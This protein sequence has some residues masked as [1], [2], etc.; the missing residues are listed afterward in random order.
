MT[1]MRGLADDLPLHQWLKEAVWPVEA[2]WVGAEMVRDGTRLAIAEMLLSGTTCFSDQYY[3]PE[4]VA[5]AAADMHMRA[6]VGTPVTEYATAWAATPAECLAKGAEL[7][8]DPFAEHPLIS[9]CF[10][11][12]SAL[13]VSDGTFADL[14]VLADQLDKPIQMHLHESQDEVETSV[15]DCGRRPLQRLED[16]GMVNSS[17][18]AVHA[19]HVDDAEIR[20][21]AESGVAVAH[22][23]RSNLKLADGIAPVQDFLDAG[24]TVG[25]GTDG[26]AS[27]NVLDMPGEMRTAALL[28]KTR[29][30]RAEALP[31]HGA[32]HMA[33]L[34][35]AAALGIDSVTGSIAP[36]KWADLA[37]ID[38]MQVNS[39]PVYDAVSQVVYTVQ[40]HQV[41]DVWVAGRHQIEG[42]RL[43][44]IDTQEI[45][46]RASEWRQRM[47]AGKDGISG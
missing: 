14:R 21:L 45:L 12:H 2:R 42:G 27:N 31:A 8:H 1:L 29:A 44:S 9:T 7:V 37:C 30:G 39:Q 22:C 36:G 5:E 16:L 35:G 38:L 28:A 32:L 23:P 3:F 26:A 47:S 34:G 10:A 40:P 13:T 18:L 17:L 15:A 46:R 4:I 24:I 41:Q 20:L 43:N 19:V 25:L 6:V 11:P 33:T